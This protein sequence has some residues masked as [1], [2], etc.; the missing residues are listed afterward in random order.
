MSKITLEVDAPDTLPCIVDGERIEQVLRNLLGNAVKFSAAN[1]VVK[2][3]AF[4]DSETEAIV[5]RVIDAGPGIPAGEESMVFERFSQSTATKTAAGGTGLG[6]PICKEII[7]HHQGQLSVRNNTDSG[8]TFEF[9]L[10]ASLNAD[11]SG[12][13]PLLRGDHTSRKAA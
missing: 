4:A 8:A 2:L 1:S 5:V 12:D 7:T 3:N 9:T 10:P 13:I 11:A 6:L